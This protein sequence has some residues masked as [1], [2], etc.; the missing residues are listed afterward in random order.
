MTQEHGYFFDPE[1]E[2]HNQLVDIVDRLPSQPEN[3]VLSH[4][5]DT[6]GPEQVILEV[7]KAMDREGQKAVLA[8]MWDEIKPARKTQGRNYDNLP[9]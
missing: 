2:L 3:E 7:F 5:P 4:L 8:K 6:L 1:A 9:Y